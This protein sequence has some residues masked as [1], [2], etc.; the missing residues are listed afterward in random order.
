MGVCEDALELEYGSETLGKVLEEFGLE[1]RRMDEAANDITFIPAFEENIVAVSSAISNE[2]LPYLNVTIQSIINNSAEENN[3]DIIILCE[4]ISI[5]DKKKTRSL[6][7]GRKNFSIRFIS[8]SAFLNQYNLPVES[9]YK[10]IIYAR[11]MLPDL[12]RNYERVVYIDADVIL[13]DDIAKL[14]RCDLN[15]NLLC[16]V[17]DTGMLA[18]YH[19]PGNPERRYIDEVL[20]L[21][22]PYDYFNSGVIV[23]NIPLFHKEFSTKFLFEYS[24]SRFWKWRDQDVFMTL[25][26]GRIGHVEQSWNVLVPYFRDE[27]DMLEEG[28]LRVLKEEYLEALEKPRLVHFIGNGFLSLLPAPRWSEYFWVFA[29]KTKYYDELIKRAIAFTTKNEC[30]AA[31][32]TN[33][34][35]YRDIVL[36][37]FRQREIGFRYILKYL[38][39]WGRGKIS[40]KRE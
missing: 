29:K 33:A 32:G 19:T 17:R 40:K 4:Q 36:Q 28:A 39:E 2:Y 16:A 31:E 6:I 24:T 3:Y 12:M 34:Y 7:E 38:K 20:K 27:V 26:D 30:G 22:N 11:L 23:F 18:W 14:Y 15:D 1:P 13:M 10:P 37:Q 9:Q 25:C 8:V 21:K 5:E 35:T